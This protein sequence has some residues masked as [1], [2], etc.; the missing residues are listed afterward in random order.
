MLVPA[1]N[2][3]RCPNTQTHLELKILQGTV[4]G[5]HSSRLPKYLDLRT[6]TSEPDG[7]LHNKPNIQIIITLLQL[8]TQ[9]STFNQQSFGI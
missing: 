3:A 6:R 8:G 5:A 9:I 1:L 4:E 7:P 2:V